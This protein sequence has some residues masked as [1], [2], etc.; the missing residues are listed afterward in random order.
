MVLRWTLIYAGMVDAAPD[1][2][3]TGHPPVKY[4]F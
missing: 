3:S 2:T 4:L 1:E